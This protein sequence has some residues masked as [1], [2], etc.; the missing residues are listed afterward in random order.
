[1]GYSIGVSAYFH[2]SSVSLFHDGD[3]IS[4]I[5]EE[6]FSRIKGDNNF[7]RLS[8]KYLLNQYNLCPDTID[9]VVF[10]EKPLLGFLNTTLGA[11]KH[12]PKSKQLILN[13]L[14]KIR[15]SGLFFSSDL[16][17]YIKLPNKKII[18]C[19]H[20]L[21]HVL[22]TFPFILDEVP[23]IAAVI[24]GVG[25]LSCTSTFDVK[26]D[27]ITLLT[28]SNYPHSLGLMY[29]AITDYLGFNINEGEYKVMALASYGTG[30]LNDLFA[31]VVD[32]KKYDINIDSFDFYKS[33]TRS[34]GENFV[35]KFGLAFNKLDVFPE[36]GEIEFKR[37]AE[38]AYSAQNFLHEKVGDLFD[39]LY[40]NTGQNNFSLSGGV[41]LNSRLIMEL[42]KKNYID[43]LFV[44]PNPGDSGA[45]IGA[46][47][48]GSIKMGYKI[49]NSKS[50]YLGPPPI[51]GKQ[52]D[53]RSEFLTMMAEGNIAYVECVKLIDNGEIVALMNG[54][55]EVGPRALGHR[56]LICDPRNNK[57]IKK[58]SQR[59]K[60]RE[61]FRPLAPACLVD[62]ADTWFNIPK[63]IRLTLYWMGCL[64]C[65]SEICVSQL[66]SICHVD[67]SARLQ[68]VDRNND[69]LDGI[70]T[71]FL[72]LTG[73][74]VLINT[75]LNCG[76]DP[77]VLDVQDGILSIVRMGVNYLMIDNVLY[78][79]KK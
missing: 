74:P 4:F 60:N 15:N 78:R 33:I 3:L 24:D 40:K 65:P 37:A 67:G 66:P 52:S 47:V 49:Q 28:S 1:M 32:D 54:Q 34:Y 64:V 9:Y 2:E 46:G 39:K 12:L 48:F 6:Y 57:V 79:V 10:Y 38:I 19:A 44:P 59:V 27:E 36:I 73:I 14:L 21:S 63:N 68:I 58:L 42:S 11:I 45:A 31:D 25:D 22:S 7:P 18:F 13:N 26:R 53:V 69:P 71:Q 77:I 70:L 29:S 72:L 61:N 23:H 20:H 30:Q 17:K 62:Y 56:S 8:L 5:R 75:S 50:P 55:I 76:G 16:K 35:D 41:A 43:N 51:I